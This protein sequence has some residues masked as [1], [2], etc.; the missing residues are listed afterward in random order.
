M[1]STVIFD[2]ASRGALGR[3]VT[4]TALRDFA[5]TLEKR[6]AR[7]RAFN[8]LI[9]GD[10]ELRRLNRQFRRKDYPTDVLSFPA[11]ADVPAMD[12]APGD[13]RSRT[14]GELAISAERALDQAREQGHSLGDELRILMLHGVL[15][16]IGLDHESDHGEMARAETRWRKTF[17][18]PNGLIERA[19]Q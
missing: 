16:L 3:R 18:L 17:E 10:A 5:A 11:E 12:P 4:Q 13:D 9:T 1:C 8:C 7:G 2:S 19:R 6:V 15:H 14:L